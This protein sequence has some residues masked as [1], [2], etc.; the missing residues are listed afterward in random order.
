[1][2]EENYLLYHCSSLSSNINNYFQHISFCWTDT[3]SY[4]S[5]Q[6]GNLIQNFS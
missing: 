5:T 6:E 2:E 1:M 3:H 4:K